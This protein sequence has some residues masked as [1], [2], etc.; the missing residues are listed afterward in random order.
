MPGRP[1]A[2]HVVLVGSP[3][4]GKGMQ[5][6]RLASRL[7]VPYLSTGEALRAEM[8][9]G[10]PLGRRVAA[11]VERGDLVADDLMLELVAATM[12][13]AADGPGYVLD[14][15]PRT[16]PQARALDRSA[17]PLGPPDVVIHLAVPERVVAERLARR[18]AQEGRADDARPGVTGQRLRAYADQTEPLL[19]HYRQQGTLV[20]VDGDQPPDDVA[21]AIVAAVE[22]RADWSG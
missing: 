2:A 22:A 6:R 17:P 8:T 16:M 20:S 3:G 9:E 4:S 13:R 19:A 21:A 7:G 14:G 10:T 1:G 5:G 15:F 11:V 18:A 12:A